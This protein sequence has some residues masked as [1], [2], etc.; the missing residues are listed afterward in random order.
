MCR[1]KPWKF[2]PEN[3]HPMSMV[4]PKSSAPMPGSMAIHGT[5]TWSQE[6]NLPG[7]FE[8]CTPGLAQAA[9]LGQLTGEKMAI[10]LWLPWPSYPFS[11][12]QYPGTKC[13][14][15]LTDYA[16]AYILLRTQ[17]LLMRIS[18]LTLSLRWLTRV[19]RTP[20]A[21]HGP[22]PKH[23]LTTGPF[24]NINPRV[25]ERGSLKTLP[26]INFRRSPCFSDKPTPSH[27]VGYILLHPVVA[28]QNR[29]KSWK[30]A[31]YIEIPKYNL[32]TVISLNK[33][34][35]FGW[36]P[37][38]LPSY[39]H[40]LVSD[41]C[42][43]PVRCQFPAAFLWAPGDPPA[44]LN[45]RDCHAKWRKILGEFCGYCGYLQMWRGDVS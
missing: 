43:C 7:V 41:A 26:D 10:F 42:G 34:P 37:V 44:S 9:S 19:L 1:K 4:F 29:P 8:A 45:L 24:L 31:N 15:M 3:L 13:Y 22:L 35:M 6:Q 33:F 27:I 14:E 11:L 17:V 39:P 40:R 38:Y 12:R 28:T 21:Y 18:C 20:H 16:I 32:C 36:T 25:L 30:S 2:H 5:R 23:T